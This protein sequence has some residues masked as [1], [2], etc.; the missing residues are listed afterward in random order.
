[1]KGSLDLVALML[2]INTSHLDK[3][4]APLSLFGVL[5]FVLHKLY[6]INYNQVRK[7]HNGSWKSWFKT[8]LKI[9]K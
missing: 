2:V 7:N 3:I 4:K 9:R 6:D 8:F 1:M 5:L